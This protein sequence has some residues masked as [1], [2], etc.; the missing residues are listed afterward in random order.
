MAKQKQST[1]KP[2]EQMTE[3]ERIDDWRARRAAKPLLRPGGKMMGKQKREA[4]DD[5]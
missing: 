1:E 4:K 2:R 3:Q 5:K